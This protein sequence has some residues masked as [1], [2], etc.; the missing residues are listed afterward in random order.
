MV[1]ED[2][3]HRQGRGEMKYE[4]FQELEKLKREIA[5]EGIPNKIK[6]RMT[7]LIVIIEKR[8]QKL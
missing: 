1:G 7:S 2:V 4:I 3:I 8:I 5:I 6:R